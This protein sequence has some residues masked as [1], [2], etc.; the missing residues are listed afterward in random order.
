MTVLFE[1]DFRRKMDGND[2]VSEKKTVT[3]E[4]HRIERLNKTRKSNNSTTEK[5]EESKIPNNR[6]IRK[7]E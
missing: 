6:K 7:F 4:I 1:M 3:N 5:F 2:L